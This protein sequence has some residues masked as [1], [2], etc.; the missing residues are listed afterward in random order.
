MKVHEL[1]SHPVLTCLP[2]DS[3]EKAARLLWERDCGVLP[4]V[5]RDGRVRAT[6]TDRDICMGAYTRGRALGDMKVADSMSPALVSCRT[7]D[8]IGAAAQKM[9]EH[10]VR[11]LPVLDSEGRIRGILSLNDLARAAERDEGAAGQA[12]RVLKAVSRPRQSKA[13]SSTDAARP[14][15]N[16][17]RGASLVSGKIDAEC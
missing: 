14:P 9:S 3:L 2:E 8:E 10:A 11:R 4:V 13:G 16:V 7:D 12:L 1:M 17:R 15:A 5:D 6:I